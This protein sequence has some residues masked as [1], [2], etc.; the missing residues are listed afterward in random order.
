MKLIVD[1]IY[2]GGLSGCAIRSRHRRIRRSDARRHRCDDPAKLR[3]KEIL[4]R[5]QTAALQ[6]SG[7]P[8]TKL[9][10][11]SSLALRE[12]EKQHPIEKVGEQL[13]P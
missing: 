9:A 7:S 5:I 4:A 12:A 3:M 11:K 13:R 1:L 8:K 2:E 10:A 6:K